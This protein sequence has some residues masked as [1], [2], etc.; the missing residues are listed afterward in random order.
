MREKILSLND[1]KTSKSYS[2][3]KIQKHFQ[4][5]NEKLSATTK[6]KFQFVKLNEKRYHFS[7]S[8][9]SF[10]FRHLYLSKIRQCKIDSEEKIQDLILEK[11]FD[12]L[13]LDPRALSRN[14]RMQILGMILLQPITFCK[15]KSDKK[16]LQGKY[17]NYWSIL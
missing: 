1:H 16:P 7:D 5:K 3:K 6:Y 17:C 2:T 15:I 11:K 14:K 8:I 13:K 4:I 9:R 10:P 12:L